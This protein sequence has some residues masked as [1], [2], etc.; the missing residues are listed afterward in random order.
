V[1]LVKKSSS[2]KAKLRQFHWS[3]LKAASTAATVWG[4]VSAQN[5]SVD[6]SKLEAQFTIQPNKK[7][8]AAVAKKKS[9]VVH[10]VDMR[11]SHKISIELGGI[12]VPFPDIKAALLAMDES[13]LTLERLHV[14]SRA[15]PTAEELKKLQAYDGDKALLGSV[16]QYFLEVGP[17]PRLA[18]RIRALIF[19]ASYEASMTRL[20][21]ELETL[22][23]ASKQL[24]SSRNFKALLEAV[25][26]VGNHLNGGSFRG[27]AAG[28]KIGDLLKLGDVRGNNRVSL[29]DF[30]VRDLI[31]KHPSMQFLCDELKSTGPASRLQMASLDAARRELTDGVAMVKDEILHA[32]VDMDESSDKHD[33]LRDV[34][35]KFVEEKEGPLAELV[36]AHKDAVEAAANVVIFFGEE[37]N[38]DPVAF[39]KTVSSFLGVFQKAVQAMLQEIERQ[40]SSERQTRQ[41]ARSKSMV[42]V[43][44]PLKS[45]DLAPDLKKVEAAAKGSSEDE[46]KRGVASS[47]NDGVSVIPPDMKTEAS[48]GPETENSCGGG[49]GEVAGTDA[50]A[51][52]EAA[53]EE[54]DARLVQHLRQAIDARPWIRS[55]Q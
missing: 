21:G 42:T 23:S 28:F 31:P 33:R 50:A 35:I 8:K 55:A 17:I 46:Q 29:L 2:P 15:V 9:T 16:E 7:E 47:D 38:S 48:E 22:S 3:K 25:L 11:R 4:T 36:T 52:A 41:R 34:L 20:T 13:V 40:K 37:P 19:C 27:S 51:A 6:L 24:H 30:V 5:S 32:A 53:Q 44:C 45:A 10:I 49:S 54:E 12:R 1:K 26:T 43:T 14:L 18:R 39:F